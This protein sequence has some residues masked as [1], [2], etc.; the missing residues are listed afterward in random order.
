MHSLAPAV[1]D[2]ILFTPDH[3]DS[4]MVT[5][6]WPLRAAF[7]GRM[8]TME[9]SWNRQTLFLFCSLYRGQLTARQSSRLEDPGYLVGAGS[10]EDEKRQ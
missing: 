8:L 1:T 5:E 2:R 6:R 10:P 4:W 9:T 3:C 7:E